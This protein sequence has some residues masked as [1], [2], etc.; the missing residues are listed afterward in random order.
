VAKPLVVPSAFASS[1]TFSAGSGAPAG[2]IGTSVRV[3]YPA[4]FSNF[5][6]VPG[7]TLPAQW[8]NQLLG[9]DTDWI[10]WVAEGTTSMTKTAHVVETDSSGIV[11]LWALRLGDGTATGLNA[12]KK[13][14]IVGDGTQQA[15]S[16]D[17]PAS[18]LEGLSITS[19]STVGVGFRVLM[20]GTKGAAVFDAS[21]SGESTATFLSTTQ[22]AV[23]A[24]STAG[25]AV[26][27]TATSAAAAVR[28]QGQVAG[29]LGIATAAGGTGV[30]AQSHSAGTS[31]GEALVAQAFA[32]AKA[33]RA[34]SVD[35]A[36][37]ECSCTGEQ[38][39][40]VILASG[41]GAAIRMD[42]QA[43]PAVP[44]TGQLWS[45]DVA[46]DQCALMY[47]GN[48]TGLAAEQRFVWGGIAP[49]IAAYAQDNTTQSFAQN[50][51]NNVVLDVL[52]N[53]PYAV[54]VEVRVFARLT[55]VP[56]PIGAIPLAAC[57]V[58]LHDITAGTTIETDQFTFAS[59]TARTG[60]TIEGA[61]TLP[62]ATA[63]TIQLRVSVAAGAGGSI[64][65]SHAKLGVQTSAGGIT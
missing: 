34:V 55:L 18:G 37:V 56:N 3:S 6:L 17:V 5:G 64:D 39:A 10:R 41:T 59:G 19:A 46:T 9:L 52:A 35:G 53:N 15:A 7:K 40:L 44:L 36:A 1:T 65:V 27:A 50:T 14:A 16:I 28:G 2:L 38:D 8:M 24:T 21:G 25:V 11:R 43:E 58:T 13:L 45:L 42:P 33:V 23:T 30:V 20:T 49:L 47:C 51:T 61:Y 22:P 57:T 54:G 32:D 62:A 60:F 12:T 48:N 29:V 26:D 31:S 63:T 4:S